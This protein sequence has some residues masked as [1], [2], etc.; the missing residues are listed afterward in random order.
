MKG[1]EQDMHKTDEQIMEEFNAGNKDSA[2]LIFEKYKSRILNFAIRIVGIRADAEDV[3]GEV[4]LALISGKYT[5]DSNAKFS[6]WLFTVARN[7]CI[8]KI[9]KRKNISGLYA[10]H[11]DGEGFEMQIKDS[12]DNPKEALEKREAKHF[13][14]EAIAKLPLEQ[15]EA[16]V[17]R[18]YEKMSYQEISQTLNVT[19]ENVKILIFRARENLKAQLSSFLNEEDS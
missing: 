17:L 10:K 5:L 1:Q 19:L 4:F 9:R 14:Q 2:Y 7:S 18:E 16:I 11:P 3:T 12:N 13:V 15:K 6:T 8:T